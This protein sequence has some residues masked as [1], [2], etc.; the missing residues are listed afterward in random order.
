MISVSEKKSGNSISLELIQDR[1]S[2]N[3]G[4]V[5]HLG[6]NEETGSFWF[7]DLY[8]SGAKLSYNPDRT[9]GPIVSSLH[10]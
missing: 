10:T 9:L 6:G 4:M 8:L 7:R 1:L 5:S 3:I 2:G